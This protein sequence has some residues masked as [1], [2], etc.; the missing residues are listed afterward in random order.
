MAEL[1]RR[2]LASKPFTNPT[3]KHRDKHHDDHDGHDG[4]DHDEEDENDNEPKNKPPPQRIPI[5]PPA[6]HD[7]DS[8]KEGDNDNETDHDDDDNGDDEFDSFMAAQPMTDRTGISSKQR[9]KALDKNAKAAS[10]G[11]GLSGKARR[12]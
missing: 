7:I 10:S 1:R 11:P 6:Q 12:R 2:V 5:P 3:P 8:G 9:L 4:H